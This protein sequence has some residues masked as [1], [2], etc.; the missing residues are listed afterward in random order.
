MEVAKPVSPAFEKRIA[1]NEILKIDKEK[2]RQEMIRKNLVSLHAE[3][4][5]ERKTRMRV[6]TVLM[7]ALLATLVFGTLRNP[8]LY[9][10]SNIGNYFDFRGTFIAWAIVVGTAIQ[11]AI[12]SL[13]QLE[14]YRPDHRM[15]NILVFLSSLFLIATAIV[16][17][18]KDSYPGWHIVHYITAGLYALCI[19]LS[20]SPFAIFVS[21]ENPRLR[22]GIFGWL[23]AI[24][25]GSGLALLF[26]GKTGMFE[27]CFLV[28][29]L[30]FLL[31]LSLV[32]FEEKIVKLSVNFLKD[33]P[34]LNLAV[35]EIFTDIE[36]PDRKKKIGNTAAPLPDTPDHEKKTEEKA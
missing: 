7:V 35:E 4:T 6:M 19:F 29:N 22:K 21:R 17:A 13:F 34:N 2:I 11:Y 31:Y 1:M 25:G 16:P 27:M 8:L 12:L 5:R 33:E 30:L 36:K 9:T 14:E 10:L 3:L 26:F 28:G 20:L 18:F 15:K 23:I 32:Q 24:W